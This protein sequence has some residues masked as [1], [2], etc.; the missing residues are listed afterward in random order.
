MFLWAGGLGVGG[1]ESWRS[2]PASPDSELE[3]LLILDQLESHPSLILSP[4]LFYFLLIAALVVSD[5][6]FSL[7]Q[8]FNNNNNVKKTL[9]IIPTQASSFVGIL[10]QSLLQ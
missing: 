2:Q 4:D 9:L 7:L 6:S 3:Q 5:L 1:Q 8:A 10:F